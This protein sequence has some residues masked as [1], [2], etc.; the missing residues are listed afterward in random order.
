MRI[1][2][3]R[4]IKLVRYTELGPEAESLVSRVVDR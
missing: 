3:G 4:G 2:Q 1:F